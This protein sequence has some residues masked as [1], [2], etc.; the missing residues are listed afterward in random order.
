MFKANNN[1]VVKID[2]RVNK[3]VIN[4]F[5]NLTYISNIKATKKL[6]FLT[7]I[8]KKIFHYLHLAFMQALIF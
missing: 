1:E 8:I 6:I 5:R 2:N 4:F 7:P 3:M